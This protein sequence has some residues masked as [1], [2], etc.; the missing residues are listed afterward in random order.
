[1]QVAACCDWVVLERVAKERLENPCRCARHQ[2]KRHQQSERQ[3][4]LNPCSGCPHRCAA[5]AGIESGM[6]PPP[7]LEVL[8]ANRTHRGGEQEH[9]RP[10][11]AEQQA[12]AWAGAGQASTPAVRTKAGTGYHDFY[13]EVVGKLEKV[14]PASVFLHSWRCPDIEDSGNGGNTLVQPHRRLYL[15]AHPSLSPEPL[16]AEDLSHEEVARHGAASILTFS[17]H[18]SA[19]RSGEKDAY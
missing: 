11:Y 2:K 3:N 17:C 7:I 1:M 12:T 10:G 14:D 8:P 13:P 18:S 16:K 9:E 4:S 15:E 19:S 6:P 5:I